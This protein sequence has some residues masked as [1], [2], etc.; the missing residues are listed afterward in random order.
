MT[1]RLLEFSIVVHSFIIGLDLGTT[2][3]EEE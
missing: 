1:A 3:S 2:V